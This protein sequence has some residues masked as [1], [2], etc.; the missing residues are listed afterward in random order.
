L[1]IA[2]AGGHNL[3]FFGPPG[4]G[5]TL[6][7]KS[8]ASILPP[9]ELGEAIEV[10]KIYSVAGL[11]DESEPLIRRRP[12]RAPHHS[13]SGV[14]IIGGGSWPKPGEVSLSHRGVLFLDEFPEF[15]RTVIENLRQPMEEGYV[16]VSR[17]R[18]TVRFPAK[19]ILAAAMNPC[20]CG[21][22][23]DPRR[24]C[25]CTSP[26]ILNYQ[27]KISGP[28]LDRIDLHYELPRISYEE[29]TRPGSVASASEIRNRV[30]R[31]R[32][33]QTR[34]L[35][36]SGGT[37]RIFTNSEMGL[38]DLEKY[39]ELSPALHQMLRQAQKTYA[40]SPRNIH[41]T[42]RVART[43]ADLDGSRK[44]EQPHLG[45]ALQYR[46]KQET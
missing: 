9:L 18:G 31:A 19:F 12:F 3:L 15:S 23:G 8:I 35:A 42:L 27:K 17:A 13:A 20:P 5:K 33:I 30:I 45:E 28:I 11:L 36:K 29:L 32:R 1:E 24:E 6:L 40:M 43:I 37:L 22:H 25:R 34:R 14:A 16:I 41:R 46:A 38:K 21:F 44:I 26:Q 39:C 10:T 2:A 7:A 4:T